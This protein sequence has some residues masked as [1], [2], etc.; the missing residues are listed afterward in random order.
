MVP[1]VRH[2]LECYQGLAV[3][4]A[5]RMEPR[6]KQVTAGQAASALAA[7][8]AVRG[9]TA[10]RTAATAAAAGV[11]KYGWFRLKATPLAAAAELLVTA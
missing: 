7:G 4:A 6:P 9:W 1:P 2:L 10:Q 11:A 3:A 8:A 5:R